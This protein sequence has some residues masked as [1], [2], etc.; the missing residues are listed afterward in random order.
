L[1][2]C[3]DYPYHPWTLVF[4]FNECTYRVAPS[5]QK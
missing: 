5:P 2:T 1:S 3:I 4:A